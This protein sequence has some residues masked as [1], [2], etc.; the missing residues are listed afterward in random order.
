[1]KPTEETNQ[2]INIDLSPKVV[3]FARIAIVAAL[4]FLAVMSCTNNQFTIHW[5]IMFIICLALEA[6]FEFV[7]RKVRALYPVEKEKKN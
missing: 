4:V 3:M 5:R 6:S 2:E 7:V 1:M